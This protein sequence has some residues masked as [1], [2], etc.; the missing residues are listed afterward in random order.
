MRESD[1]NLDSGGVQE[2]TTSESF[3]TVS[4]RRYTVG[5]DEPLDV[6]IVYA[7]AATKG[8]GPMEL[9]DPLNDVVDADALRQL[10]ASGDE[11][12][13]ATIYVDGHRVTVAEGGRELIVS[14][15]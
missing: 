3:D 11:S 1:A 13:S 9:E 8:V 14:S 2:A 4:T 6:A 12:L 5:A 15:S 10:F 7:V